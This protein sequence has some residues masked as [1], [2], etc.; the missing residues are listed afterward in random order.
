M[1]GGYTV[2]SYYFDSLF[3]SGFFEKEDGNYERKKYRVRTYGSTGY[4]ILEK[5]IKRGSLNS[6]KSGE[7]SAGDADL[8][9]KG[10]TGIA[11]G[12][13]VTDEIISEMY[14]NG[15][16]YAIYIEYI[17]QPFVLE[18]IDLRITF[19]SGIGRVFGN[20]GLYELAPDPTPLFY[21]GETIMEIKYKETL[22]AWLMKAIY[23]NAPAEFSMSKYTESL[24]CF[25]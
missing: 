4:Y 2:K 21:N 12:N 11:T 5:K 8:L 7:I 16:R 23:R 14:M 22:P 24:R 19:D 15:C 25:L 6:K 13:V 1:D 17:R 3:Y 18:D 10:H 20:Y 9:I